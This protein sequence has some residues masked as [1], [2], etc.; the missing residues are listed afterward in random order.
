MVI[1]K[2]KILTNAGVITTRNTEYAEKKSRLGYLVFCKGENN[3][4]KYHN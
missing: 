3:I 2:Y 4:Y 1:W